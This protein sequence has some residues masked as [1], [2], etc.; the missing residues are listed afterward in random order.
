MTNVN[1]TMINQVSLRGADFITEQF[2]ANGTESTQRR[3][4]VGSGRTLSQKEW[5]EEYD[6]V[7][8]VL[9][10]NSLCTGWIKGDIVITASHCADKRSKPEDFSITTVKG[11]FTVRKFIPNP[12]W[13]GK[14]GDGHDIMI[15]K[16]NGWFKNNVPYRLSQDRPHDATKLELLGFG[17]TEKAGHWTELPIVTPSPFKTVS[18]PWFCGHSSNV[19]CI[20]SGKHSDVTS[21]GG[22]S[23]GPWFTRDANGQVIIVGANSFGFK[24]RFF[25]CDP[26]Y[27]KTKACGT[28]DKETGVSPLSDD[29]NYV[30][31]SAPSRFQWTTI[32]KKKQCWFGWWC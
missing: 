22:D 27:D 21:C 29:Y 11:S 18:C 5:E 28:H 7:V 26:W 12:L 13:N 32:N 16:L 14:S 24:R 3:L 1:G 4:F 20:N 6:F 2:V 31:R 8:Q 9:R 10:G 19:I 25:V 23:G 17:A 15:L 30:Q